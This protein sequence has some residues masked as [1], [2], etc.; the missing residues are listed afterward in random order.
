MRDVILWSFRLSVK[1]M[2]N[3]PSGLGGE[4]RQMGYVLLLLPGCNRSLFWKS[5]E[6]KNTSYSVI[7][8]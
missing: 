4:E 5:N 7:L 1:F 6:N 8:S 3:N 2:A